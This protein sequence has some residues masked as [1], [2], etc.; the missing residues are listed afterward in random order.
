MRVKTGP[1]RRRRHKK[2]LDRTKGM[3]LAR[4]THIK[5]SKESDLHK[6]QHQY[7]GR[8]IR[9][10]DFRRLWITRI[11]AGLSTYANGL[12]YSTFIN[13]L[14]KAS[15]T[16]IHLPTH[17]R[18]TIN[19]KTATSTLIITIIQRSKRTK[20]RSVQQRIIQHTINKQPTITLQINTEINT[21][22][23]SI[24]KQHLKKVAIV[25]HK[26]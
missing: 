21:Q 19:K 6:G 11:N 12:R 3:R 15:N 2:V 24:I 16:S 1:S 22:I 26:K 10:R 8:K 13:N 9:K 14:K 23:Q 17:I 4:G 5:V 25:S 7:I 20:T 18:S